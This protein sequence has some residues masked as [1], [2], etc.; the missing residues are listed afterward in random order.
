MMSYNVI[1]M[2]PYSAETK[3]TKY[4]FVKQFLFL[5]LVL[6]SGCLNQPTHS[7]GQFRNLIPFQQKLNYTIPQSNFCSCSFDRSVPRCVQIR[8]PSYLQQLPQLMF[9]WQA[10]VITLIGQF[11]CGCLQTDVST[12]IKYIVTIRL[13]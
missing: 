4:C 12:D 11:L 2:I 13:E 6:R 7:L 8:L 5:K 9:M 1:M 10:I 3:E